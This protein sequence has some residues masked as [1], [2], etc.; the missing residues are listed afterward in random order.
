MK[1]LPTCAL[2]FALCFALCLTLAG[3]AALAHG[4]APPAKT[5]AV[6]KEQKARGIAGGARAA[7]RSIEI[8]MTEA[9]RFAPAS[10]E[11]R[12]GETVR[13]V[14]HNDTKQMHEFVL[15]T[16]TDLD[17]HAALM[18]KF[19]TMAHDEPFMAHVPPGTRGEIV[20]TFNRAGDFDFAGLV[21]GHDQ[22]GLVGKVRVV[23]A[24]P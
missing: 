22:A 24:R 11:V 4:E 6:T 2:C 15:G 3:G 19:P 23:A 12:P 10:I 9:M 14:V 20:W 21:A 17:E 7:Q 18:V 13:F 16:K 1:P 8:R 5:T